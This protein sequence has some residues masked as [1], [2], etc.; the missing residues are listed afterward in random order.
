MAK[1]VRSECTILILLNLKEVI[2]SEVAI[3]IMYKTQTEFM[4]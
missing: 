2:I 3:L 4:Q 1:D